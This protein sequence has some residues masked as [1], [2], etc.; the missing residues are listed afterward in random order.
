M[1]IVKYLSEIQALKRIKRSGFYLAGVD[2]PSSIASHSALSAQI[3]YILAKLEGADAQK[4]AL[5][6]L[7]HDN[8][9]VRIGDLNK[10][11]SRYIE[12]KETEAEKEHYSNLDDIGKELFDLQDQFKQRNT[13]EGIIC[14]DAD[15]LECACEAKI[16]LERGYKGFENWLDDIGKALVTESAK[17][18]LKEIRNNPDFINC[19]WRGLMKMTYKKL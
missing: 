17:E 18:I 6:N 1:D 10:I 14:K 9:E 16:Y 19:W 5:I 13:K 12:P 4:C 11:N 7:F 15:W 3:A 2:N 8:E